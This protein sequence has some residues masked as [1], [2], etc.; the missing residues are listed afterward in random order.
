MWK[1]P[2]HEDTP[3]PKR[4]SVDAS[5]TTG[6]GASSDPNGLNRRRTVE[7]RSD[8]E[9]VAGSIELPTATG[10]HALESS[11]TL[12][13]QAHVEKS[14]IYGKKGGPEEEEE[15]EEG[16]FPEGGLKAWSV[17]LG[18][19]LFLFGGLGVM[20][21]MGIFHSHLYENDLKNYTESAIGWIFGTHSFLAFLCGV[22]IG[23]IFDAKGPRY[24]V[25]AGSIGIII[26]FF[27]LSVCREYY[28]YFLTFGVLGGISVS[29]LFTPAIASVGHWFRIKRATATG[30]AMTGGS[31]GGIVFPLVYQSLIPKIGF[32]WAC[33][34]IG[35][36]QIALLIPANLLLRSRLKPKPG[37]KASIDLSA[38]LDPTFGLTTFGVF[39]IEWGLFVPLTYLTSYAIATGVDA[40]FAYQ[41]TAIFNAGSVLGRWLPNY[42]SDIV[43]RFNVM[44]VTTTFCLV[45]ILGLWLP[46][47]HNHNMLIAFTVLYGFGSGSGIGLTPVC[48]GQI[49]RTEDYGKRYGTCY[50]IAS[51]ASL[52]GIPIAGQIL[53]HSGTYSA[54]IWFTAATYIASTMMF[55]AARISGAGYRLSTIF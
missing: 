24:L 20:N 31:I 11:Q 32:P 34:V 14:R 53:A 2:T 55:T 44:I 28:Q 30:I 9:H 51:F 47:E 16:E 38:L 3:H 5:A 26:M 1:V 7:S 10:E 48:V 35:F 13:D 46:S 52:T 41:L 36:I 39:L 29:L 42:V 18:S 45:M 12:H 43:G 19:F 17:V 21:T 23:P 6:G 22:Q 33:R 15:E 49:C 4:V 25:L 50:S 27:L 37:S 8:V 40:S 54:L